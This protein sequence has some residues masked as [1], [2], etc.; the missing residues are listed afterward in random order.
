MS[1]T[2][3]APGQQARK[4]IFITGAGSGLGK[5]V[6]LRFAREG[7]RVAVTDVDLAA[8][9][10]TLAEVTAAGGSGFADVCNV[11]SEESFAAIAARLQRE[12]NGVDVLVNNA[13]VATKGTV[14]E[15]SIEQWQWVL[16][17]NLLGCVRGARAIV[18]LLTAQGSGHVVNIASFAGIANPPAMASYNAAKAAVISLSETLRHEM[19]P[20]G[21]GV[22]AVCPS[23]F[24]TNL[25]ATS[26]QAS[27]EQGDEPAPQMDRIVQRLMDKSAVTADSVA[28]DIFD[29]VRDKRFLV[30]VNA[31]DRRQVLLKRVS[32]EF[33]FRMVQK[34]TAK[35]MQRSKS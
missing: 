3:A 21:V 11:T 24:K 28:S 30:L 19:E 34:A 33:Y 14:V 13:G 16:N 1:S 8:A 20:H 27:P 29:A 32:P 4:R 15:S 10:Q 7:W 17:I 18:P 9:T 35:F 22:S 6:A 26:R 2:P 25:I 31:D 5:A 23:F 12:W